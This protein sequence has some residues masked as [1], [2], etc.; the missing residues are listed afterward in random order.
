[1]IMKKLLLSI[2]LFTFLFSSCYVDK[3][4]P[5]DKANELLKQ[6]NLMNTQQIDSVFDYKDSHSCL[7]AAYNLQWEADSILLFHQDN[8]T[9]LSEAERKEALELGQLV[10]NLKIR[11]AK[12][13][14]KQELADEEKEFV[15]F[16][17][18][19]ADSLTGSIMTIYFNKDVTKI[20]AIDRKLAY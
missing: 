6:R 4:P 15:G 2:V 5:V 20:T 7:M 16:S 17:V 8:K 13:T 14:L 10:Y 11:A 12:N 19:M 9:L 18:C 1:M 3:R